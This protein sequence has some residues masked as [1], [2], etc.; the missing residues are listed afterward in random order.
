M[1]GVQ[2]GVAQQEANREQQTK[3][4]ASVLS[5]ARMKDCVRPAV[6]V[7]GITGIPR[8]VKAWDGNR[9]GLCM[10]GVMDNKNPDG[11]LDCRQGQRLIY[12]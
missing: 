10:V 9:V 11:T 5:L 1:G 8:L 4:S 6:T 2:L 3:E 7:T 12:L